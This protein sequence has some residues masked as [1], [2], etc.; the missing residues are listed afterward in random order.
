MSKEAVFLS[1]GSNLGER[2]SNLHR[3]VEALRCCLQQIRC[4]SLYETRPLYVLEQPRFL[5]MVATGFCAL[6]PEELLQ[7]VL[8]T[9]LD[10]GRDRTRHVAKGPRV[11]DIDILLFGERIVRRDNLSIPHP[12]LCERQFVLIPLLELEPE[13]VDP[14]RRRPYRECLEQLDDQGVY[15]FRA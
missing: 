8:A 15:I 7:R 10:L 9:E 6:S 11:I 3:A 13:L 4:S 2:E 1:L 12:G 5:N 14:V